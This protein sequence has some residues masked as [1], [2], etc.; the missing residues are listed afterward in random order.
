[1]TEELRLHAHPVV[2]IA[3]AIVTITLGASSGVWFTQAFKR[4]GL[5]SIL[6]VDLWRNAL[7]A[8]LPSYPA[9]ALRKGD[10]GV[11]VS[12][13]IQ[14]VDGSVGGVQILESPN[15]DM[16][17]EVQTALSQWRFVP[18]AQRAVGKVT[19]YF[20]IEEG[21]GLV[22]APGLERIR[23]ASQPQSRQA[24]V[25]DPGKPSGWSL[26]QTVRFISE[27]EFK[28]LM[29]GPRTVALDV[30]TKENFDRDHRAGTA[31]I[32][33]KEL[34]HRS[35]TELKEV[36]VIL[37]DCSRNPANACLLCSWTLSKLPS[38]REIGILRYETPK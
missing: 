30:R 28:R 24:P 23:V 27:D 16:A 10:H 22:D 29:G 35:S 18:R 32:P 21:R 5:T 36:K 2:T 37:L 20:R 8:P 14:N 17:A 4:E 1:M 26:P 7:D 31:N 12:R 9:A 34:T 13:V 6:E 38:V 11:V 19:L 33:L 15:P 25:T 3:A